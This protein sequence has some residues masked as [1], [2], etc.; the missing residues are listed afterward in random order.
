MVCPAS[1][2]L[3]LSSLPRRVGT[4]NGLAAWLIVRTIEWAAQEGYGQLSLNF[5]PFAA[6]LNGEVELGAL[7][8]LERE[9]LLG[10]KRRL[11]LQLDNLMRFNERFLP[12]FEPRFV[13]YERRS[14]LPRVLIAAMA[15]EGYLPFTDLARGRAWRSEPEAG[16]RTA[17]VTNENALSESDSLTTTSAGE[18]KLLSG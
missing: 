3:S 6:L 14:D 1:S 7:Q 8:R 4:P 13:A 12:R 10:A 9:A 15:A 2:S 16:E 5:T 18:S 17:G 11:S